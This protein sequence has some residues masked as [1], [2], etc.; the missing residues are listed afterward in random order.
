MVLGGHASSVG[1]SSIRAGL[2]ER[3]I[4]RFVFLGAATARWR[5]CLHA[6]TWDTGF[7]RCKGSK[8]RR[9]PVSGFLA[10]SRRRSDITAASSTFRGRR[11]PRRLEAPCREGS[12]VWSPAGTG[13]RSGS[14]AR[15]AWAHR[16]RARYNGVPLE[17]TMKA[18]GNADSVRRLLLASYSGGKRGFPTGGSTT[19]QT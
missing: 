1:A 10:E 14:D 6:F 19:T 3:L 16:S 8:V 4:H 2:L 5:G 17:D 13:R 9:R 12:G 18:V 7:F 15:R 11:A